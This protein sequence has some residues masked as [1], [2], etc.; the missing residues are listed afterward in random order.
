MKSERCRGYAYAEGPLGILTVPAFADSPRDRLH[1]WD[2]ASTA[3]TISASPAA[4]QQHWGWTFRPPAATSTRTAAS[5][6]ER[7]GS[8][9]TVVD[10]FEGKRLNS[11]NDFVVAR[12]GTVF[13]T[14]PPYG[15]PRQVEGKELAF[16]GVYRLDPDGRL[17]LWCVTC[18]ANGIGCRQTDGRS[19]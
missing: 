12:D 11:P 9:V 10:R 13:F 5:Q 19:T 7:D 8:I 6:T 15:L 14:D 2:P 17:R 18:P 1:K 4:P 3:V 16:Q